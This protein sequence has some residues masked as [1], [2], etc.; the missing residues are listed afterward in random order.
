MTERKWRIV[1]GSYRDEFYKKV[2]KYE[3]RGYIL[4]PESFNQTMGKG[5][6]VLMRLEG[7]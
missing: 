3:R 1:S 6:S 2:E 7:L 5:F 4:H